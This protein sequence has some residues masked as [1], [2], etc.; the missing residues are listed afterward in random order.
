MSSLAYKIDSLE[1]QMLETID[2]LAII[3]YTDGYGALR[4]KDELRRKRTELEEIKKQ[5]D[6][7][8]SNALQKHRR[9]HLIRNTG[10]LD[11]I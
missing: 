11:S 8:Y 9:L 10:H 3:E 5:F 1:M 7:E 2:E 4:L 6:L